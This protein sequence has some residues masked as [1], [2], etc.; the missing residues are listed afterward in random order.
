MFAACTQRSVEYGWD[1]QR[2]VLFCPT[3]ASQ[4]PVNLQR[5]SLVR[6]HQVQDIEQGCCRQLST[7]LLCVRCVRKWSRVYASQMSCTKPSF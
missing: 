1:P 2:K 6:F 5:N 3:H 7:R 4:T